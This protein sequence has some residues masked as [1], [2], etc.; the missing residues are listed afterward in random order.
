MQSAVATSTVFITDSTTGEYNTP[1]GW[2]P[3]LVQ[4]KI[5]K[6]RENITKKTKERKS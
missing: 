6:T 1:R 3:Q 2:I 5:I 4:Q